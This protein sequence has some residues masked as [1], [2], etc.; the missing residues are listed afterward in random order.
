MQFLIDGSRAGAPVALH[1]GVAKYTTDSLSVGTHSVDA[2]YSGDAVYASASTS[3][4]G[5]QVVAPLVPP[6]NCVTAAAVVTCTI[7]RTGPY[8]WT[9]PTGVTR[10]TFDVAGAQ[11]GVGGSGNIYS[12][13]RQPGGQGGQVQGSLVVM[14]GQ[15]LKLIV[16]SMAGQGGDGYQGAHRQRGCRG[17]P[18]GGTGGNGPSLIGEGGGGGASLVTSSGPSPVTLVEAGGGGGAGAG[19]GGVGGTG[20]GGGLPGRAGNQGAIQ[21]SGPGGGG[22]ATAGG[23]GGAPFSYYIPA[24]TP[25]GNGTKDTGGNGGSGQYSGAWG[26]G[27]GGGGGGGGYYGGGGGGGYGGMGGGGG[28]GSYAGPSL[29]GATF[30]TGTQPGNGKIVLTY[31]KPA[32][33]T[34]LRS[35][36]LDAPAGTTVTFTATVSPAPAGGTVA[37]GDN[38]TVIPSCEARPV[39]T[40]TGTATCSVTYRSVGTHPIRAAYS[41]DATYAPSVSTALDQSVVRAN[42]TATSLVSSANPSVVTHQVTYKATVNPVPDGGTVAFSD[43][44]AVIASCAAQPVDTSTGVATCSVTYLSI[45]FA[46]DRSRFQRQSELPLQL[47]FAV[48]RGGDPGNSQHSDHH[49]PPVERRLRRW[50]HRHGGHDRGRDQISGLRL[51]RRLHRQR[52]GGVVRRRWHLLAHRT[53]RR[54]AELRSR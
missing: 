4:S 46:P 12:W 2:Q 5:G 54:R 26:T 3:L 21:S 17:A 9:V 15:S 24:S 8:G 34:V 23:S 27:G 37:F 40:S 39:G 33:S 53:R 28:G 44:R 6:S 22:T 43:N 32:T 7:T 29:N 51:H 50:V 18:G 48:D 10:V 1:A 49:Q 31:S 47:Q 16:G 30:T 45:G 19:S 41:G 35:S 52:P 25:G 11:G 20:G 13:P 38:G 14:P 42:S 36:K